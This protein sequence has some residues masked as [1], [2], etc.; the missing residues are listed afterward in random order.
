MANC[1]QGNNTLNPYQSI[2]DGIN[3]GVTTLEKQAS[4]I[5]PVIDEFD[6]AADAITTPTL[7]SALNLA[8]NKLTAEAICASS[9][10]I[11]PLNNLSSDCLLEAAASIKRYSKNL[12]SNIEDGIGLIYDILTLPEGVLFT[13]FQ[14]IW[15]LATDIK[16]L[17]TALNNKI[18]CISL[19]SSSEDYQSQIDDINDRINTVIDDLRLADDG[20]FDSDVFLSNLSDDLKDNIKLYE[21]KATEVKDGIETSIKNATINNNTTTNPRN[22][23]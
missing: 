4:I 23:Y 13:L 1:N 7:P 19:S 11:E 9:T 18:E 8:L 14:K 15:G 10:D 3:K 2:I 5:Q 22:Y 20:S 6:D 16:D 21:S 17:I 12:L